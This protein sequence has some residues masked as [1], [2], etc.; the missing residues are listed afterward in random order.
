VIVGADG[1]TLEPATHGNVARSSLAQ[2][3]IRTFLQ[4]TMAGGPAEILDPYAELGV[5]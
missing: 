3:Q 1:M 5:R 4:T 2:L